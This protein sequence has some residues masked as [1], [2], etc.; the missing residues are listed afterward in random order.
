MHPAASIIDRGT[1]ALEGEE[2][3]ESRKFSPLFLHKEMRP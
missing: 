1:G 3:P 2:P